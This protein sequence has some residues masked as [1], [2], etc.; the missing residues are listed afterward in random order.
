MSGYEKSRD[1]GGPPITLRTWAGVALGAMLI[2]ALT[3]AAL[4]EDSLSGRASVIDGDT[5]EIHGERIRFNGIDAP[6]SDQLCQHASGET[7]RCGAFVAEVLASFLSGQTLCHFVERDQYGRYVGD[8]YRPDGSSVSAALVRA[9][10]AM[11]WP[12]HS[13]GRYAAE[14]KVAQIA[15]SGLWAGSFQPPWEF[16]AGQREAVEAPSIAA[17]LVSA[18]PLSGGDC[19]IKGNVSSKGERIYHLPGQKF[20]GETRISPSKGERMFC[21]EAEARSAGWRKAKQ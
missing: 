11:D 16:R 10:L 15:Q 13:G 7:F 9:G 18:Q 5:I 12:R 1:Y 19:R 17:P 8:C 6:E 2:F 20:Y 4:A 21:S 3:V 14:Q